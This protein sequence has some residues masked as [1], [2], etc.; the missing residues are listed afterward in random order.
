M[1]NAPAPLTL[2]MLIDAT[3]CLQQVTLFKR[4]FGKSVDVANP[5]LGFELLLFDW[6]WGTRFLDAPALADY[7]KAT[8]AAWVDYDKATA[9][10]SA[11]Y[12]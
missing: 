2:Q 7:D 6:D 1:N 3:A 8:A 5:P 10:A 12:K 9:P 4:Q 11:D